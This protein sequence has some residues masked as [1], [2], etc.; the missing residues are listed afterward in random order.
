[1]WLDITILLSA[2]LIFVGLQ[3]LTV[4]VRR[5]ADVLYQVAPKRP[6]DAGVG[7]PPAWSSPEAEAPFPGDA[8]QRDH[9]S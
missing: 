7:V 5:V 3:M 2:I 4:A 6:F 9:P 8:E 1:M